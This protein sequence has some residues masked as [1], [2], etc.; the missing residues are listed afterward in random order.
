MYNFILFVSFSS[1]HIYMNICI[2]IYIYIYNTH[3]WRHKRR[4]EAFSYTHIYIDICDIQCTCLYSPTTS[5]CQAYETQ[6][7]MYSL[8]I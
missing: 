4:S 1:I 3:D 6:D 7:L 2:Y 5:E 8:L